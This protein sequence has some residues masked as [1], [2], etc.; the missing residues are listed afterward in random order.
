MKINPIKSKIVHF[1]PNS[2]TRVDIVFK[3][4]DFN[5]DIV[6]RYT[7]LGLV[8]HEHLDYN[9]TAKVVAQSASRA[10]GLLIA[11]CKAIGGFT[12]DVYTKLY[13]SLVWPV[14]DYGSAIWGLKS[15]S[16][17][18][19]IHN[20]AMRF[21][22]G[23]GKYTPNA[24]VVGEMGWDPPIVRQWKTICNLWC[25][26]SSLSFRRINRRVA[27][28]AQSKASSRCRNWFYTVMN[29]LTSLDCHVYSTINQHIGKNMLFDIVKPKLMDE[30]INEWKVSINR[31][32]GIRNV[33][34]NKLRTY[35]LFKSNFDVEQ[36][37]KMILPHQHRSAFSKFRCGVAPLRIETGRY[38][39]L[40]VIDRKCTFCN[41]IEDECHVLF[42]CHIYGE[43]RQELYMK[44]E[45]VCPAFSNMTDID[46]LVYLFSNPQL[47]RITAKTC[48]NILRKRSLIMCK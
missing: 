3:C 37:C 26:M 21:F 8:L 23:V 39:N 24:A 48:F 7:Y 6:D 35:S 44:A 16:C 43:Y 29:R 18:N 14:I 34:R 32:N 11:K 13:N 40:N 17:I 36:Y 22:L 12:Y 33:G 47:I 42:N 25:R 5:L 41:A 20:R 10:L 31:V 28:W 45:H 19:A 4:G 9:V 27:L 46:K 1:R 2:I 38:E 15:F 30:F